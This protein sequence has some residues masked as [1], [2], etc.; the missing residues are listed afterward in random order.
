MLFLITCA[1]GV[2]GCILCLVLLVIF[3]VKDKSLLLPLILLPLFLLIMAGSVFLDWRGIDLPFGDKDGEPSGQLDDRAPSDDSGSQDEDAPPV[4]NQKGVVPDTSGD[5]TE[6]ED[7]NGDAAVAAPV[8]M[9]NSGDLGSCYVEIKDAFLSKDYQGEPA[10]VV[11]YT[12]TNNGED[13]TAAM[14]A[15]S[16]Q[17]FQNGQPLSNAVMSSKDESYEAGTLMKS[18]RSGA[19]TDVQCAF[20]LAAGADDVR[21]EV[22]EFLAHAGDT[23]F[24]VFSLEDIS[25]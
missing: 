20:L 1:V 18:I 22:S 16:Q 7:N 5:G 8:S 19:S 2:A 24:R 11:T 10:I 12:W 17:A 15:L 4:R 9:E 13:S 3:Y 21:F 6:A 25:G 23:V 14:E